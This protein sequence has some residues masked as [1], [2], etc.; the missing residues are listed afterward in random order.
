MIELI[1]LLM[2]MVFVI[3]VGRFLLNYL[4]P[5]VPTEEVESSSSKY[6]G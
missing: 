2:A 1:G 4:K 5:Q 6:D 3:P